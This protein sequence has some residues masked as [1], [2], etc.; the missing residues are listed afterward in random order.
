MG[1]SDLSQMKVGRMDPSGRGMT[2][3]GM[4]LGIIGTGLSV[5][6]IIFRI[7]MAVAGE[8]M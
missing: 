3:A 8:G 4:V 1:Q 2:Q 5:L 7:I 6:A